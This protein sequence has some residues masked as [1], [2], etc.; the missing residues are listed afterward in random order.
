MASAQAGTCATASC[1]NG[2][3]TNKTQTLIVNY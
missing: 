1:T 2:A 3:A